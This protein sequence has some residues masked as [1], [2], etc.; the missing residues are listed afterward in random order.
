MTDISTLHMHYLLNKNST[1]YETFKH[2]NKKNLLWTKHWPLQFSAGNNPV[3]LFIIPIFQ[4]RK[5]RDKSTSLRDGYSE[6]S[7]HGKCF[8]IFYLPHASTSPQTDHEDPNQT[9]RPKFPFLFTLDYKLVIIKSTHEIL[10]C[11][12]LVYSTLLPGSLLPYRPLHVLLCPR[13][14]ER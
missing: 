8:K 7:V 4:T 9:T 2:S 1:T 3:V 10:S 14:P 6:L 5:L 12:W 11:L 13:G